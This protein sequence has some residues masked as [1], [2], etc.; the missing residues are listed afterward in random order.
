MVTVCRQAEFD[1]DFPEET[2]QEVDL[3]ESASRNVAAAIS[4]HPLQLAMP[5]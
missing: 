5:D 1:A 3:V 4:E 2:V